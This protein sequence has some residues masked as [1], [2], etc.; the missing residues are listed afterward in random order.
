ME[1]G[2]GMYRISRKEDYLLVKF[3]DDFDFPMIQT[4][5]RHET[6]MREYADTNDIWL[7]G[8]Y[9]AGINHDELDLMI[10]SF[11]CCCPGNTQRTKTAI[12]VDAG[13]TGSIVELWV[14]GLKPRVDFEIEIFRTLGEAENW[15]G[16]K[17]ALA[18]V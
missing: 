17:E 12:V 6:A 15:L 11:E 7:I 1:V 3:I 18:A 4:A 13:L 10:K 8:K 9:R 16:A 5:I 2:R 14:H